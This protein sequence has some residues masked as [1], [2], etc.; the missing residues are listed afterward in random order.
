MSCICLPP[1]NY[2]TFVTIVF[3]TFMVFNK[4]NL[5]LLLLSG[6]HMSQCVTVVV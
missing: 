2:F 3:I 4:H 6:C 5:I 1:E